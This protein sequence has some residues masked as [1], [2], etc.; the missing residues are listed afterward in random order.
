MY[1]GLEKLLLGEPGLVSVIIG[2]E[3]EGVKVYFAHG[4]AACKKK[5][6]LKQIYPKLELE[7]MYRPPLLLGEIVQ[8]GV[9]AYLPKDV[10]EE[11]IFHKILGN[12]AIIG[13]PD[14]YSQSRKS[15][16]ELKFTRGKPEP[17]KHHRLRICI[18][19]WLSDAE[20]TYLLYCSPTEFKEFE[21]ND[22]FNDNKL[23]YLMNGWSS[24]M[25][26]WECKL[27]AHNSVCLN[28]TSKKE[29][30][31][32]IKSSFR[33]SFALSSKLIKSIKSNKLCLS[34]YFFTELF[35]IKHRRINF[36]DR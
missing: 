34:P 22:E 17:L 16:Y 27:C 2:V 1:R 10:E 33:I 19:K 8:R 5:F 9:K 15:V 14:F 6:E 26:D 20:H 18:Y 29:L 25:W 4:L 23:N 13:T 24:P 36:N 31:C 28:K 11:I 21:V 7:L 12:T 3:E 35:F 30:L 32:F